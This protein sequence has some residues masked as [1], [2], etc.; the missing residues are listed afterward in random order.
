[1]LSSVKPPHE[2]LKTSLNVELFLLSP[3]LSNVILH[4]LNTLQHM[5]AFIAQKDTNRMSIEV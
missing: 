1:M 3:G 5:I 4:V 2:V